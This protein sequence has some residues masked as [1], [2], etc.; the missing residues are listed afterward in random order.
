MWELFG[1]SGSGLWG[2]CQLSGQA[3]LRGLGCAA[4]QK[5]AKETLAAAMLASAVTMTL[6]S[7]LHSVAGVKKQGCFARRCVHLKQRDQNGLATMRVNH[8]RLKTE[9][10]VGSLGFQ[11]EPNELE[12][13]RALASPPS[14]P[15]RPL[16]RHPQL[17]CGLPDRPSH[18]ARDR[19]ALPLFA[20]TPRSPFVISTL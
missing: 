8:K 14:P 10:E 15:S 19:L 20:A 11:H 5:P 4:K 7:M 17:C 12:D 13:V 2:L 3:A 6:V 1:L 16:H 18:L 9:L